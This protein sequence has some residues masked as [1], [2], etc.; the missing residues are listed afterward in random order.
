MGGYSYVFSSKEIDN[1]L[2]NRERMVSQIQQVASEEAFNNAL[3]NSKRPSDD[4]YLIVDT[5]QP[6]DSYIKDVI[7]YIK[8]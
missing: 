7:E 3:N 1:R 6:L 8:S 4:R 5:A 2:K